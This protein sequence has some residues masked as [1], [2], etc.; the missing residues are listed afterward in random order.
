MTWRAIDV[1]GD[2]VVPCHAHAHEAYLNT[3]HDAK[4]ALL[5]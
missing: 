1:G 2:A 5:L 4:A 3:H